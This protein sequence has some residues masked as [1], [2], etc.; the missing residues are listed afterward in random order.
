VVSSVIELLPREDAPSGLEL[1]MLSRVTRALFAARR[2]T[3]RN[4]AVAAFGQ[5]VLPVL[6]RQRIDPALRAEDLE[7]RDFIGLARA[8]VEAEG[9]ARQDRARPDRDGS[10]L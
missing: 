6:E 4:N 3:I 1:E 10:S 2:K 7:P 9:R 5:E 8:L